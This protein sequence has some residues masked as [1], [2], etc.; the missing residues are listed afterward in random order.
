MGWLFADFI[1][2]VYKFICWRDVLPVALKESVGLKSEMHLKENM[3]P[4][5][6]VASETQV[7]KSAWGSTPSS[8]AYIGIETQCNILEIMIGE[9]A[10]ERGLWEVAVIY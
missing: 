3:K 10:P 2:D 4:L 5:I 8:A 1:S 7:V 9:Q 6:L